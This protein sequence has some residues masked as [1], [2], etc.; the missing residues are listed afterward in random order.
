M[1]DATIEKELHKQL[2][3]LPMEKQRQVL[4]FARTLTHRPH[5]VPGIDLLKFA[6]SISRDDLKIMSRAIEDGCGKVDADEW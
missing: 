6:G 2:E 3:D 1:L 4:N 5:G